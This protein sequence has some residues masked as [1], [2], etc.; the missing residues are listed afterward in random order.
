MKSAADEYGRVLQVVQSY[1][2]DN[3]GVAVSCRKGGES[4]ADLEP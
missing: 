1:A 2:I 3:E 4:T